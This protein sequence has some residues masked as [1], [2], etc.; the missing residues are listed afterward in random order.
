LVFIT[1]MYR[2]VLY[3][4]WSRWGAYRGCCSRRD[5]AAT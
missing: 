4:A 3:R 5:G 1:K 2:D